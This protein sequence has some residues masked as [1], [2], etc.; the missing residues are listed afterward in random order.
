[1]PA[2]LSH[3]RSLLPTVS[4]RLRRDDRQHQL[5]P[6]RR[7]QPQYQADIR[8]QAAAAD[9]DQP[10]DVVGVL[11]DELHGDTTAERVADHGGLADAEFVEQIA[12][13]T[14]NVPSE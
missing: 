10:L 5:R 1:M 6:G 8:T 13:N 7:Q 9:Q 4:H 14:A 12:D 2:P 3:D 11:V